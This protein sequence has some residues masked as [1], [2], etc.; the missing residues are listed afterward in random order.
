MIRLRH[1][2]FAVSSGLL[3]LLGAFVAATLVVPPDLVAAHM[4]MLRTLLFLGLALGLALAVPAHVFFGGAILLL[5]ISSGTTPRSFG[6][7]T[8]YTYDVLLF[9]VLVRGAVPRV[10][11]PSGLR[12]VDPVVALRT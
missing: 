3:A 4:S 6:S 11:V 12:L 10:R 7:M 8:L 5:G 2:P 1:L 9:L